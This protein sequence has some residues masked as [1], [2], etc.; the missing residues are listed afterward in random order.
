LARGSTLEPTPCVI[1]DR[2]GLRR[3]LSHP[4]LARPVAFLGDSELAPL[5]DRLGADRR[6]ADVV[7]DWARSVTPA[8]AYSIA[9]WLASRGLLDPI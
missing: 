2:I 3:A 7:E 9:G 8:A 4:A 1:G 5:L 6:L